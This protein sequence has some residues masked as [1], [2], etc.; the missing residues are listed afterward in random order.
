MVTALGMRTSTAG[1]H[2]ARCLLGGAWKGKGL[3]AKGRDDAQ[4]VTQAALKS[5]VCFVYVKAV[6]AHGRETE[7]KR[8]RRTIQLL[9]CPV[10]T[11][12]GMCKSDGPGALGEGAERKVSKPGTHS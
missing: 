2:S 3:A 11:T 10:A 1:E 4:G 7:Y 9:S 5:C 6:A 8:R 12:V